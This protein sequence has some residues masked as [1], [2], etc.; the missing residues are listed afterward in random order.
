M[1]RMGLA[2]PKV[3]LFLHVTGKRQDGYHLL[4]SLACFA[5]GG[6]RIT[7]TASEDMSLFE[8][9]PFAAETGCQSRNLVLLAADQLKQKSGIQVGARILLEKNIPVASGIGGGSADAAK[10]IELLCDLWDLKLPAAKLQQ[11]AGT[12][13]ADV[14]V[15]LKGQTAL[16]SGIGDHLES[17][18]G[19][20]DFSMLL[21]NPGI[22]V[23]TAQVF[24]TMA[25]PDEKLT[26]PDFSG[27][28][29]LSFFEALGQC[30]NHM[31]PAALALAPQIGAV[32]EVLETEG[33]CKLSRMSGSGATC[34]GLFRTLEQAQQTQRRIQEQHPHWWTL[35]SCI[36]G[37]AEKV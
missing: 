10:T 4:E 12:L 35:A 11:I 17:V 33:D 2:R 28:D 36:E 9:G 16:M 18:A 1:T 7:V 20:P 29:Q 24:R 25:L 37:D 27:M 5:D 26:V 30:R 3:N 32:L 22:A 21:I 8:T 31:Q 34:F 6:D 13:G 23:S 14:P 15:C 19:L